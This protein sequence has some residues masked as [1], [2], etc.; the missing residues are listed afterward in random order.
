M[1][2]LI[3]ED[4]QEGDEEFGVHCLALPDPILSQAVS[5]KFRRD[6][7]RAGVCGHFVLGF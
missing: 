5:Q 4:E 1:E 3:K 6:G 7:A 2:A